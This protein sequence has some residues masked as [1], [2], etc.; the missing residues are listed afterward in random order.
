MNGSSV[1]V[2]VIIIIVEQHLVG[3][4]QHGGVLLADQRR[5]APGDRVSAKSTSLL[6]Q[7]STPTLTPNPRL[8]VIESL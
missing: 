4:L 2:K 6:S 3:S 5:P 7:V 1:S 8:Q